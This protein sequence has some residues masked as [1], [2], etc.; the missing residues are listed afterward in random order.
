MMLNVIEAIRAGHPSVAEQLKQM[1][2]N[3]EYEQILSL[4]REGKG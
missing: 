2:H 1:A 3:F 4:L